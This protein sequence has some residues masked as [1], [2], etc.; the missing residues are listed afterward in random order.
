V[1]EAEVYAFSD[2][3]TID[4]ERLAALD[5]D[6]LAA[7][8]REGF[9]QCAVLAAASLAN[10]QRLVELKSRAKAQGQDTVQ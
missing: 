4:R 8:H 3:L 6:E 5:G 9:L 7:L 2:V 10:V 1:A